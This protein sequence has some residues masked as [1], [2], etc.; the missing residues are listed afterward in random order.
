MVKIARLTEAFSEIFK[1]KASL[2]EGQS[3]QQND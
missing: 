1:P 3:L 2:A